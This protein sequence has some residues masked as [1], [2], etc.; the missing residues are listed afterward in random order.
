M[1]SRA[2]ASRSAGSA[3][4]VWL[5]AIRPKT[6][7]AGVT[8]VI[9]GSAC[10]AS[11]GG[12]RPGAA[13]AA[14]GAALAIQV[15]TN[16][17]NDVLD[18]DRG[19]DTELRVGPERAVQSGLLSRRQ[20][21]LGAWVAFGLAVG[22]GLY[23]LA[24]AGWPVLLLGALSIV[25]GLS[26][27]A[28]PWALAYLGLGDVFVV[29]FFGFVAVAGTAYV[30]VLEVPTSAWWAGLGVGSLATAIL[31]VNNLRDRY[32]DAVAGKRTWA[33]RFGSRFTRCEYLVL[34]L[35]AY[36][37]VVPIAVQA[38][39]WP[40]LAW[41]SLPVALVVLRGVWRRDGARLNKSLAA[42]AQLLLVFG[43]LLAVGIVLGSGVDG[44]GG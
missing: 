41:L 12:F 3:A 23:L 25:A 18:F 9:V 5:Q 31:V 13:V 4:V 8:P 21:W 19:A 28:G 32:T 34:L 10:A 30:Q 2:R 35:S 24:V 43:V 42:T 40:L 16:L 44:A 39:P 14:L 29:L 6:L 7:W 27:T 36:L 37:S 1:S 20:V 15:G 17:S 38:G 33:V 11:A 22:C 26:Y